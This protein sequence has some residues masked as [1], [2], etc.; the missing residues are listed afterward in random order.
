MH[1]GCTD[2]CSANVC[3]YCCAVQTRWMTDFLAG[4]MRGE[5]RNKKPNE[6]D[7]VT[8][9]DESTRDP[10]HVKVHVALAQGYVEV[11]HNERRDGASEVKS[12]DPRVRRTCCRKRGGYAAGGWLRREYYRWPV[13]SIWPRMDLWPGRT[14]TGLKFVYR[15][16]Q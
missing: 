2:T 9:I 15:K 3:C 11:V 10:N 6:Q 5:E 1:Y 8:E 4:G 16:Q 7:Y 14:R 13:K 12:C